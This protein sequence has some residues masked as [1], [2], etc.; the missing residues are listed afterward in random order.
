MNRNPK[1][2]ALETKYQFD[3]KHGSHLVRLLNM[4]KEILDTGTIQVK[5]THDREQLLAIKNG[6]WSYE[7][8]ID[9]ADKMEDEVKLAYKNSKLPNQPNIK[10]LDNLCIE[11]VEK[12]ISR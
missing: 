12:I 4:G 5:R 1:R 11:I 2:A 6:A 8:L 10:F 3:C 7:Q 9:Y